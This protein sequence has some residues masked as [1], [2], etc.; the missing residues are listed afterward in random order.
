MPTA[1]MS[2]TPGTRRVTTVLVRNIHCNSCIS[3]I[4][5]VLSNFAQE[6][7]DINISLLCQ[8]VEVQH[9]TSLPPQNICLALAHAAFDVLS[10]ST[11]DNKGQHVEELDFGSQDDW[12]ETVLDRLNSPR[13][14]RATAHHSYTRDSRFDRNVHHVKH[15]AACRAEGSIEVA[16]TTPLEKPDAIQ[17][18]SV[19][20]RHRQMTTAGDSTEIL[21]SPEPSGTMQVQVL[22]ISISGMTCAACSSGITAALEELEYV[23]KVEVS[24]LTNSAMVEYTGTED[25][26]EAIISTIGD[27]GFEAS[28]SESKQRNIMPSKPSIGR[29]GQQDTSGHSSPMRVVK[30]RIDGMFCNNCPSRVID[31]LNSTFPRSLQIEEPPSLKTPILTVNYTANLG[32]LTIRD[33]VRTINEIDRQFSTHVYHPPSLEDRS[34][35]MQAQ[36]RRKLLLRLLVC[37]FV[38]VPTFLVGVLWMSIVPPSN[39]TRQY[40]EKPAWVG[41]VPLAQWILLILATPV[42]FFAADVFHIR[43]FKEI[44]AL[45]RPKSQVPIL[46][47]FYRFGSMSLLV[48]AGTSVAYIS[49]VALLIKG[50]TTSSQSSMHTTTYFDTVVFLTTFI[51]IGKYLE[52]FSKA[53]TG[54][55]VAKLGE[56]RPRE[57][58]LVNPSVNSDTRSELSD[59]STRTKVEEII[60]SNT[61][62]ISVDLLEIGDVVVV[63]NGSSPPA[64]GTIV[65]GSSKFN[66]SS[67]TGE[68]RD[69]NKNEGDEVFSGTVNVGNPVQVE[70]TGLNGTSM[71]DQIISVVREGQSKRAPVERVVDAITGY[72]VPVITAIAIST[73]LTWF[74]LGQSGILPV[75]YLEGQEGGWAFW[76]LNFA[77]AVF[78]GA[79]PCGIGLA[80]PTALFVGGALAAKKGIL[81]RGGGEAFQE[82]SRVDAV[83]F[84]K[85]GTLTEGGNPTVTDDQIL[86]EGEPSKYI[87]SIIAGLEE[88][89]SHPLARAL[90][91]HASTRPKPQI[92]AQNISEE[93]GQ[94]LRG[95]FT[96]S[97]GS[98]TTHVYEAAIGS[99]AFIE[100]LQQP[101]LLNY[102]TTTT[103]SDWKSQSKSIALV[104]LRELPSNINDDTASRPWSLAALFAISDPIRPSA[105]ATITSLQ[106]RGIDVYMLTGDNPATASAVASTLSIPA[107]HVFAGVLPAQKAEKIEWLKKN[108]PRRSSYSRS[109][110][111]FF[112]RRH[113]KSSHDPKD[114]QAII[115]FIG[116]GIND[117]PALTA[118][119]VSIAISSST[120][121][122]DIAISSAS[123]VLLNPSLDTLL[124]LFDLSALVFRRIKFNFCWALVYNVV[125]VPVAAGVFFWVKEGGWKLSPV[126]ASLAMAGSSVSVVMS[127]LA[128]KWG[129]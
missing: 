84:D 123:F 7:Y 129:W 93:P 36:E 52:A 13:S 5:D 49:S 106:A 33:I 91:S 28:I 109:I 27:V 8:T 12:L 21:E 90:L 103:L 57:A 20:P 75:K 53:K 97:N 10:F 122:N 30:L 65:T 34:Q 2:E 82:A 105:H 51:L 85:T 17:L 29:L 128:M 77:I 25:K 92:T 56:L 22:T 6:I 18:G 89:S 94:G 46:R 69:V 121:A 24:L 50:A 80:A 95:T 19:K 35:M 127:S 26:A 45:W 37:G 48:S 9:R 42:M 61:Q 126:W 47:R 60:T 11:R 67:L 68:S 115:A 104:A 86:A 108:A 110:L 78:V 87:W 38:I 1:D 16:P 124:K 113:K 96:A 58:I 59:Q 101:S 83:V 98:D 111:S 41:M 15:C 43:A 73:F 31:R 62:K 76:S 40:F 39:P 71:L 107:D 79:C 74:A 99:E 32:T 114:K 3:Y 88:S 117:A 44:R 102:F 70:I 100:S 120:S 55:A 81:V 23:S 116:D 119:S 4:K 66:E 54:S 112:H 14:R 72:F 63:P 64:D 125:L 118:A